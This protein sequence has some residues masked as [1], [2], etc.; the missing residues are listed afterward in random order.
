MRIPDQ[1]FATYLSQHVLGGYRFLMTNY[2]DG[3]RVSM[4]GLSGACHNPAMKRLID[5]IGRILSRRLHCTSAR[6]NVAQGMVDCSVPHLSSIPTRLAA[7]VG[8]LS[9]H[10]IEQARFAY[11]L[12]RST[13][14]KNEI[15][16]QDFKKTFCRDVHNEF[17]GVW[18][19]PILCS[20]EVW[21]NEH[22]IG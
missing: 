7:K 16:A 20:E 15:I 13:C 1:A 22:Q 6:G 5:L 11:E 21:L 12:Y 18:W 8:L 14:S 2:E 10:C 3:D 17:I 4:F 9:R 19:V